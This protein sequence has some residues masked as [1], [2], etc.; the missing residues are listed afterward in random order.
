MGF[1]SASKHPVVDFPDS[2]T[3][4]ATR[5]GLA[6]QRRNRHAPSGSHHT[7]GDA[8]VTTDAEGN[9][10]YLNPIA[11]ELGQQE[12]PAAP[13]R[14]EELFTLINERTGEKAQ[15]PIAAVLRDARTIGLANH[16]ALL[17]PDG[18]M[19]AIE[20]SAAPMLDESGRVRGVVFVFKDISE[21]R[22]A[23]NALELALAERG[24]SM[25][26]LQAAQEEMKVAHRRKD[27]FLATLAHELR[28][29]LAPIRSAIKLLENEGLGIEQQR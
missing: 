2:R 22:R 20:D 8:V 12:Q 11:V 16:T 13:R 6:T 25:T 5:G 4:N 19:I 28:N 10:T 18:S 23:E 24:R 9:V 26:E 14:F 29:P 15:D 27:E 3:K 1:T 7:P 17:R 21:R